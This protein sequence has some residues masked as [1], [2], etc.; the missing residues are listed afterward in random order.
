MFFR[1]LTLVNT[2]AIILLFYLLLQ[3]HLVVIDLGKSLIFL[4]ETL[5][6]VTHKI[7]GG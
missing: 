3:L 2:A 7:F 1:I 6:I 5:G 4:S